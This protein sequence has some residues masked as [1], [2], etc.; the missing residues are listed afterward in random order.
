MLKNMNRL[1]VFQRYLIWGVSLVVALICSCLWMPSLYWK[2]ALIDFRGYIIGFF[3]LILLGYLVFLFYA[4]KDMNAFGYKIIECDGKFKAKVCKFFYSPILLWK[5]VELET[6]ECLF[7]VEIK[8]EVEY[9]SYEDALKAIK[10]H[11]ESICE[12]RRD[13]FNRVSRKGKAQTYIIN[14]K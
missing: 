11:N 7:G 5:P 4:F 8:I 2:A 3:T 14:Q 12:S 9:N 6:I 13:F 10:N 1:T